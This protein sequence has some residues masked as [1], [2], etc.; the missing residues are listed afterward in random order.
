MLC[1]SRRA[2]YARMVDYFRLIKQMYYRKNLF[3]WG[4][5]KIRI[6]QDVL[7]FLLELLL[8]DIFTHGWSKMMLCKM[9]LIT[10]MIMTQTFVT[11]YNDYVWNSHFQQLFPFVV[12][13]YTSFPAA[14]SGIQ[15]SS[16]ASTSSYFA[17]VAAQKQVL[18]ICAVF[19]RSV[20]FLI[21][22]NVMKNNLALIYEAKG[23]F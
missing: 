12:A 4:I 23:T 18:V 9:S 8:C 2:G 1:F 20:F 15:K 10:I 22:I 19:D 6:L 14:G 13:L 3:G 17:A 11:E 7:D 5:V 21:P 16:P